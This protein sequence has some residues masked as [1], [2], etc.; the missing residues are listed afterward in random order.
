M[1]NMKS[2]KA[3]SKNK[4]SIDSSSIQSKEGRL[5]PQQEELGNKE[6]I[7]SNMAINPCI[8]NSTLPTCPICNKRCTNNCKAVG[9]DTCDQW[10]HYECENLSAVD[11]KIIEEN[12]DDNYICRTSTTTENCK[13]NNDNG[14]SA[15]QHPKIMVPGMS[16]TPTIQNSGNNVNYAKPKRLQLQATKKHGTN[17]TN[18]DNVGTTNGQHIGNDRPIHQNNSNSSPNINNALYQTEINQLKCEL[19]AKDKIIK[20]K[21]NKICKLDSEITTLKKQIATNRSFTINLEQEKK[22]HRTLFGP[23]FRNSHSKE[24]TA[25]GSRTNPTPSQKLQKQTHSI[26][27]LQLEEIKQAEISESQK[28]GEGNNIIQQTNVQPATEQISANNTTA[29]DPA[30]PTCP[31]NTTTTLDTSSNSNPVTSSSPDATSIPTAKSGTDKRTWGVA[32]C[33]R[34]KFDQFSELLPDGGNRIIAIKLKYEKPLILICAYMPTR[35]SNTQD[36]YQA[37]LD[38]IAEIME[39]YSA[40]ADIILGGDMNASLHRKD[41]ISRDKTFKNFLEEQKLF[42]PNQCRRQNTFYHYNG[43]DESQID[44]IIQSKEIISMYTTFMR[45]PEKHLNS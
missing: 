11:I 37:I 33:V 2:Q 40:T 41:G 39:K 23:F 44:Y 1:E 12:G 25:K 7:S 9:C 36:D 31:T 30:P 28:T 32:I 16:K 29:S 43:R 13:R 10:F 17:T 21:E 24:G 6:Q 34:K 45:E 26:T 42:I 20:S 14:S 4:T 15:M 8:T 19:E 35:G 22:G 5:T 38:E 27:D 18:T 3:V